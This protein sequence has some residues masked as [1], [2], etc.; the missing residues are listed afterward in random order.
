[1]N[2]V[3]IIGGPT[4]SG[5]SALA[6][7]IGEEFEG[8]VI[9]ADSMQVYKGLEIISG[10]PGSYESSRCPHRLFGFLDPADTFSVGKWLSMARDEIEMAHESGRLPVV[11]GGTGLYLRSLLYGL[12]TI[13]S[14]PESV[15]KAVHAKM[16]LMGS[17]DMHV[18][19]ARV[20][21]KSAARI[22]QGDQ[23]RIKRALEVFE[24]TGKPLSVWQE[25]SKRDQY[26]DFFTLVI[27]PDRQILYRDC[28]QRFLEMLKAGALEEIRMLDS[29]GLNSD[30][31]SMKALGIPQLIAHCHGELD[32][33]LAIEGA[34]RAT[35]NYVKRQVTWF[36][37]QIIANLLLKEK[38]SNNNRA[39]IF[40]EISKFLLTA[41]G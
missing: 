10:A 5:K 28:E 4:G 29:R 32:L 7:S 31:T 30:L 22:S 11:V 23:Q 17:H 1:M 2:P 14:V 21:P 15:R 26:Y 37:N 6:A 3:I 19:L 38:F 36:K 20:D 27:L 40:S 8:V 18:A 33:D 13:P 24:A 34:Q 35:R 9:N 41:A 39:V 25:G 16:A 12:D